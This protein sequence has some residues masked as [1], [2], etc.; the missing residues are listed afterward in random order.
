MLTVG[1]LNHKVSSG[2]EIVLPADVGPFTVGEH[3]DVPDGL[4]VG[5]WRGLEQELV[6]RREEAPETD[7]QTA[8]TGSR[9]RVSRKGPHT[10]PDGAPSC[11]LGGQARGRHPGMSSTVRGPVYEAELETVCPHRRGCERESGVGQATGGPNQGSFP[12]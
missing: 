1:V 9:D 2:P 7:R 6:V 10:G 12:F 3:S 8:H 5:G 4:L 11:S